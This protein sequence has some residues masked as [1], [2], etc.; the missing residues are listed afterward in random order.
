LIYP[1]EGE[2]IKK[3]SEKECKKGRLGK[4]NQLQLLE[5]I[6]KISKLCQK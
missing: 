6:I 4:I 5:K 3:F 1:F 2:N